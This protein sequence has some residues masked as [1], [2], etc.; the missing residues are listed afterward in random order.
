MFHSARHGAAIFAI[1]VLRIFTLRSTFF[2]N[3]V[4]DAFVA[5][6]RHYVQLGVNCLCAAQ[7]HTCNGRLYVHH[8]ELK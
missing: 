2:K 3:V 6:R 1:Y 4:V 8:N 7:L 5:V